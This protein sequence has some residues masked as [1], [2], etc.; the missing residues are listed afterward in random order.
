MRTQ[1]TENEEFGGTGWPGL[2][3]TSSRWMEREAAQAPAARGRGRPPCLGRPWLGTG[4]RS[5]WNKKQV[6]AGDQTWPADAAIKPCTR[7][8]TTCATCGY[9]AI[10]CL[11]TQSA[12]K[13][14][15]DESDERYGRRVLQ[16]RAAAEEAEDSITQIVTGADDEGINRRLSFSAA[17]EAGDERP[18]IPL[19]DPGA[20]LEDLAE[21]F[22][23]SDKETRSFL[24]SGHAGGARTKHIDLTTEQQT[25]RYNVADK[26]MDWVLKLMTPDAESAAA[27]RLG[28]IESSAQKISKVQEKALLA[29]TIQLLEAVKPCSEARA[30]L[31][32][33]LCET[34]IP[35]LRHMTSVHSVRRQAQGSFDYMQTIDTGIVPMEFRTKTYPPH[36]VKLLVRFL[37]GEENVQMV[38]W[39]KKWARTDAGR[40]LIPCLS[41]KK[42]VSAMW[43][44]YKQSVQNKDRVGHSAFMQVAK[45]ITGKQQ[46]SVK[47][48]DYLVAELVHQNRGRLERLIR[49]EEMEQNTKTVLKRWTTTKQQTTTATAAE[50]DDLDL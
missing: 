20:S 31:S 1:V 33:L 18:N 27:M 39:A 14:K 21:H 23:L 19:R 45:D 2:G 10:H 13:R 15:R 3:A 30:A 16:H 5:T 41:R 37:M 12:Q 47:A 46:K 25:R 43:R 9:C 28:W 36:K 4:S 35:G 44:R 49:A 40:Q 11:C 8:Q 48:V 42:S 29:N 6:L 22:E 50:T 34:D 17:L 26:V 7:K 24:Y 38:S 32:S